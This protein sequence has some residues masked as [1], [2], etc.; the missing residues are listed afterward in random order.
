MTLDLTGKNPREV[1]EALI[2]AISAGSSDVSSGTT[3]PVDAPATVGARYV[4]T[5]TGQ[6][7]I[8]VGTSSVS[9]WREVLLGGSP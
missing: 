3:D 2:A 4:N 5:T 6:S 9:D 7:W 1:W 8:A